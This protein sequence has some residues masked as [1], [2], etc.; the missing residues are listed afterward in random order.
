MMTS[1]GSC[2][3][4]L[5]NDSVMFD[6]KIDNRSNLQLHRCSRGGIQLP[7]Y[8]YLLTFWTPR[9]PKT[10]ILCKMSLTPRTSQIA[11]GSYV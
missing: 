1:R 9:L 4:K 7:K 8:R 10:S 6:F 5:F 3:T 11:E 2:Q